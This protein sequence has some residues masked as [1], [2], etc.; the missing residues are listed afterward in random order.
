M[1][2][3]EVQELFRKF[4]SPLAGYAATSVQRKEGAEFMARTL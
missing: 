3:A 4:A 2:Q 1:D